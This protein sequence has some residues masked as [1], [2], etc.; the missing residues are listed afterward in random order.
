MECFAPASR[1][2]RWDRASCMGQT[3]YEGERLSHNVTCFRR[4]MLH[5][6]VTLCYMLPSHYVT[7]F[8]RTMLHASV[9]L[10]QASVTV[11]SRF[12]HIWSHYVTLTPH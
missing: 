12:R 10:G 8:C 1:N 5:A 6:S 2:V 4:T 7:C 3:C 11:R 9:A